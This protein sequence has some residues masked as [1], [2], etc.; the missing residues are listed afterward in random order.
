MFVIQVGAKTK[1]KYE[2]Q[3]L[4]ATERIFSVFE[5]KN[6]LSIDVSCP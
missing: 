6:V 2:L 1:F 3:G 5:Y 4:L